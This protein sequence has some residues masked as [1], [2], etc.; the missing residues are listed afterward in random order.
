MD[1]SSL[2]SSLSVLCRKQQFQIQNQKW[3]SHLG[4]RSSIKMNEEHELVHATEDSAEALP[5]ASESEDKPLL[6]LLPS[7]TSEHELRS[8]SFAASG[9]SM[10]VVPWKSLLGWL[11]VSISPF[12]FRGPRT[13]GL[14]HLTGLWLLLH[15]NR[16]GLGTGLG[17]NPL[18]LTNICKDGEKHCFPNPRV[19]EGAGE[20]GVKSILFGEYN[21]SCLS[22]SLSLRLKLSSHDWLICI[23]ACTSLSCAVSLFII[24][25]PSSLLI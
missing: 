23:A 21:F 16:L 7:N 12:L 22:K 5:V 10:L 19:G 4:E 18:L 1:Q 9:D 25:R 14:M 2:R 15:E 13:L 17:G 3:L 11:S 6:L 8:D 20:T 24:P